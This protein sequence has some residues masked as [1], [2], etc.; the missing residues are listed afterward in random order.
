MRP[1][2]TILLAF[3]LTCGALPAQVN[4]DSLWQVWNDVA[5]HDTIRLNALQGLASAYLHNSPD[6]ARTVA[7]LQLEF[8][9]KKN[10]VKWQSRAL[11]VI[12]LTYRFQSDY[13]A[14][15][16]YFEQSIALLEKTG[17][18]NYLSAVYGNMG[19]VYRLQSNF[20]KAVDY[21]KKS[22]SLAEET[23]D[24]KRAAD[25]TVSIAIMYYD[26]T[27]DLGK[28]L[29]YLQKAL[30]VYEEL[31]NQNGLALV[32]GNM[33]T[34]YL[35]MGAL[36]TAL[37][38]NEKSLALQ[39]KSGDRYGQ[40]TSLHNRATIFGIQGKYPEALSDFE[41]QIAIFKS[42]GDQEG[43]ANSYNSMADLWILQKR[44][45]KAAQLC[46]SALQIAK[47]IGSPNLIEV[48]ACHCLYTAFQK[49]GK[50]K[51]AL[52]YLEQFVAANDSLKKNETIHKLRQMEFERQSVADSLNRVEEKFRIEL[53]HQEAL[54]QK[55]RTVSVLTAVGLGVLAL[56]L[57]LWAL[58]LYFRRRS[59]RLQARSDEL[60]KQ[61]LLNEIALLRTQVNPHFLFNSL[62]ILTSLVHVDP[63]LSE[64]FI[65]QL[66]RSYR[67]I[68]EQKEQSLVSL[69]TELEFIR[70]YAFLLK[71][72]FD[73]KFDLAI[74][75]P[76]DMLDTHKIAPLTLQLLVENVVKHNRMSEKE[77]LVVTVSVE[78][79][80][81]LL[82]KN[83]LQP[84]TTA[85]VSTGVGLQNIADRYALLTDR[86][87]WA[88]ETEQEFVVKVP[89]LA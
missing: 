34:I 56:A 8:A 77:P 35:D 20:P 23:G 22:L 47:S 55:D 33:S 27:G 13:A 52:G 69:R 87:V 1:R 72:R 32:Y 49:Q 65:E 43:L 21:I 46:N 44:Y 24:R 85:A 40:A 80:D 62:S 19:G 75:L 9:R 41:A 3:A 7:R 5:R 71:I 29:E 31:N 42:I 26:D 16:H 54:R 4:T 14:S 86:P 38:F 57:A 48:K 79:D 66:S 82:V 89:L 64:Q 84:R 67:Y 83:R 18:R 74:T 10:L 45:A 53:N 25:A 81:T 59:L 15:L 37:V 11:N 63:H 76:D 50:H 68:L 58:M 51:L 6:S 17:D 60:E 73:N 78:N 61:Q 2:H 30:Q 88:G 12:G 36:D 28:A 39:K 70:A